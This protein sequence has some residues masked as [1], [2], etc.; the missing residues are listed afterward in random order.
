MVRVKS[1]QDFGAGLLFVLIGA[2][3]LVFGRD[4]AFGSGRAM[5][6]GYFPTI[7]SVL[8]ITLGLIVAGRALVV[9][10]PRIEPIRLRP[11]LFLLASLLAFALAIN[12]LGV[13]VSALILVVLAAYARRDANLLETLVFGAVITGAII[14]LFVYGLGQ[15]LPIWWGN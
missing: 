6:P 10:G 12:V 8:I 4:L 15:P 7:I 11:V 2:S 9:G 14:L 1:A 3:G 13:V 5:G